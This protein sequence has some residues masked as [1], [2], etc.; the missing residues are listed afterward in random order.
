MTTSA[1][2]V[3]YFATQVRAL[4]IVAAFLRHRAFWPRA[5]QRGRA[6]RRTAACRCRASRASSSTPGPHARPL[7]AAPP[8]PRRGHRRRRACHARPLHGAPRPAARGAGGDRRQPPQP[9]L[10][11]RAR[12]HRRP[13]R[14]RRPRRAVARRRRGGGGAGARGGRRLIHPFSHRPRR[15]SHPVRALTFRDLE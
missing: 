14:A 9:P 5:G 3:R 15:M 12:R 10:A 1:P 4:P 13:A 6:L 11:R 2:R 7:R 8:R